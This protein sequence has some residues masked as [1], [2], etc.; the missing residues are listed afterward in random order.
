MAMPWYVSDT[1]MTVWSHFALKV[2]KKSYKQRK[3][4]ST[5]AKTGPK[6]G[7]SGFWRWERL[8]TNQYKKLHKM[9]TL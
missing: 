9:E 4:L 6:T 7:L 1:D 3:E 2:T 5:S 8:S